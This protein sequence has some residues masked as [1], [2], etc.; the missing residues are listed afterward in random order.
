MLNSQEF[1]G[2]V[3]SRPSFVTKTP[4]TL[5]AIPSSLRTRTFA[6]VAHCSGKALSHTDPERLIQRNGDYL[7]GSKFHGR[8]VVLSSSLLQKGEITQPVV[9]EPSHIINRF[10][11]EVERAST[12]AAQNKCPLLLLVFCHGLNTH[13]FLLNTHDKDS[14]LTV[15]RLKE[16]IAD[17]CRVTLLSTA[18]YSAGW[19]A[20]DISDASSLANIGPWQ[21]PDS[22]QV[23]DNVSKDCCG[24]LFAN[25]VMKTLESKESP[26]VAAGEKARAR[27]WEDP[28]S[29]QPDDPIELQI[30]TYD[31][32]RWAMLNVCQNK[33]HRF[34]YEQNFNFSIQDDQWNWSWAMRTG[35]PL[36]H[37]QSRWGALETAKFLNDDMVDRVEDLRPSNGGGSL[38]KALASRVSSLAKS[39]LEMSPEVSWN[40][41]WGADDHAYLIKLATSDVI[42][43]YGLIYPEV[44]PMEFLRYRF[45]AAAMADRIVSL[46]E[47]PVPQ[48]E[49]CMK[50]D[51]INFGHRESCEPQDRYKQ[52]LYWSVW[53][54][55]VYG[56]LYP[57]PTASQGPPFLRPLNYV[58]AAVSLKPLTIEEAESLVDEILQHAHSLRGGVEE[59]VAVNDEVDRRGRSWLT[60]ID[61][62]VRR[63]L[64][65]DSSDVE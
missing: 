63:S 47:L 26:L 27:H 49:S 35:A 43:Y 61:Q 52:E 37:F 12:E 25:S 54:R 7:H 29:L 53:Q 11:A 58:A 46:F 19:V 39:L 1:F 42:P 51:I 38:T 31:N 5:I 64:T 59:G 18:C 24:L 8:K 22:W 50:C 55:L 14:G 48:G 17:R 65:P 40:C 2:R 13:R 57:F 9:V 36:Q 23:S 34:D 30:D 32:F 62:K 10:L 56:K 45:E 28:D 60:S 44:Y 15:T 16:A 21:S 33:V 3:A 4:P 20:T 6:E 41:D